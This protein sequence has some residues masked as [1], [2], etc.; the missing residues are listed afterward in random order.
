MYRIKDEIVYEID[1]EE[2]STVEEHDANGKKSTAV[3]WKPFVLPAGDALQLEMNMLY[4]YERV[5][6]RPSESVPGRFV[7]PV[8]Q[9]LPDVVGVYTF[10]TRYQRLGYSHVDDKQL[11][12]IIPFRHNEFPYIV[13][14]SY[15]YYVATWSMVVGFWLVAALFLYHQ[16]PV[17]GDKVKSN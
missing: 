14:G 6:L 3:S 2:L 5:N 9:V 16:A 10:R 4:T 15:P 12:S 11:V 1:I 8:G 13:K 17:S 7:T